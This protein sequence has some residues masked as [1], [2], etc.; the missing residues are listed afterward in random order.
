MTALG[1]YTKKVMSW[2]DNKPLS[3][4]EKEYVKIGYKRSYHPRRT[5]GI[6]FETRIKSHKESKQ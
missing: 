5:A 2:L 4:E 6:I 1:N 3:E